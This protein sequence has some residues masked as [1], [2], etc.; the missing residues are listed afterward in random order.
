MVDRVQSLWNQPLLHDD[1]EQLGLKEPAGLLAYYL[2]NDAELRDFAHGARLNTD[3]LTLLEYHAPP[4]L[5]RH[6]LQDLNHAAV[7][8]AQKDVL[9]VDRPA[10]QRDN[11]LA[12]A[13]TTS[14]MLEDVEGAGRFAKALESRP[15][16]AR[17]EVIAG[18]MALAY[19]KLDDARRDFEQALTLDRNSN[20]ALWGAAEVNRQTDKPENQKEA[21]QQYQTILM[22]DPKNLPAL[23]SL[24][25]LDVDNSRWPEAADFQ[26]RVIAAKPH[27]VANDYEQ[28]AELLLRLRQEDDA[29]NALQQCLAL[30]PYNFK[31]HLYLGVLYRH[32][33]LWTEAQ[34]HLEFIRRFSPDADPGTYSLL[35]EVYKAMG[36]SKEAAEAVKFGLRVFPGNADLVRLSTQR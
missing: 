29:R 25:S 23:Q 21:W 9:P 16:T 35:Y 27:P 10:D 36:Q 4:A 20:D 24:V 26:K 5:L 33:Q 17:G 11:D 2:L 31:A 18:R 13:A 30:D 12:A 14:M 34:E 19:N 22:R 6:D 7:L 8:E 3:D 28:L 32:E 1:F 15:A